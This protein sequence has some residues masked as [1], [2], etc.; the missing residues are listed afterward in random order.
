MRACSFDRRY[1]RAPSSSTSLNIAVALTF[2]QFFFQKACASFFVTVP[3]PSW[4]SLSNR[5]LTF[6]SIASESTVELSEYRDFFSR[7]ASFGRLFRRSLVPP[8]GTHCDGRLARQ[9]LSAA[10]SLATRFPMVPSPY[11][12][13][14]AEKEAFRLNA[15]FCSTF[16][17]EFSLRWSCPRLIAWILTA[18]S[19]SLSVSKRAFLP[20]EGAGASTG[21]DAGAFCFGRNERSGMNYV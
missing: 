9:L 8:G 19:F 18:A 6:A 3:S 13:T 1:T 7:A 20:A 16:F 21:A 11:I 5:S 10:V 14:L 15:G 17:A 2:A 4:S 12:S